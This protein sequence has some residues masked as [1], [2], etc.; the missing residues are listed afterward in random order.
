M[1]DF[2]QFFDMPRHD[3]VKALN[4]YKRASNQ[5][6]SLYFFHLLFWFCIWKYG[7]L[8]RESI[9]VEA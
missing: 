3:A 1:F 8:N 4:I 9:T 6:I 7:L 2:L 5:V